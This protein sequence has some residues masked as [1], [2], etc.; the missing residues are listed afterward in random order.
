[1]AVYRTFAML[2]FC[3]VSGESVCVEY[4]ILSVHAGMRLGL[5]MKVHLRKP[6][7]V[8]EGALTHSD[9][10]HPGGICNCI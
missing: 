1:M 2:E 5:Q 6:L 8:R 4:M 10:L 3:G 7:G 9:Q